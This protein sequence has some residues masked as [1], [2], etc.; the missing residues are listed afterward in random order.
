MSQPTE[1]ITIV[2]G[3]PRSGT[4][5][6]MQLLHRGGMPVLTDDVKRPP[7]EHNPRGYYE[8]GSALRL[9]GKDQTT[10]W[11]ATA[12]GK[13]VKVIA[14]QMRHLPAQY[15][16]RVIY[17]RRKIKE[18]LASSRKMGMVRT[19]GALSEREQILAF[20]GE[21]VL[22]EIWLERQPNME[23][24]YLNYNEVLAAPARELARVRG[25]LGLPLDL[26]RMAAGVDPALYRNRC[27]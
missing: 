17:M 10:D 14:Y 15:S 7:K 19:D 18:V 3:Y 26:E 25:F 24:L 11:V 12:R 22:H 16:Y 13:A 1:F 21:Y 6:M 20:K 23:V 8:F 5:M 9:G 27:P 4:S 2:T